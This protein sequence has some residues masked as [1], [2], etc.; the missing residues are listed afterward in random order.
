MLREAK[1]ESKLALLRKLIAGGEQSPILEN[2]STDNFVSRMK[3]M[4][5]AAK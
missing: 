5:N 1:A 2:R 3:H 4:H